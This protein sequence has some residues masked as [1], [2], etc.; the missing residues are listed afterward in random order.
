[1]TLVKADVSEE[2]VTSIIRMKRISEL[3][4]APMTEAIR[5]SET[6]V[7][8]RA[9]GHQIPEDSILHSHHRENLKS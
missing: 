7:L 8:T 5:S 6:S 3:R 1:V 9:A 2:R 4:I